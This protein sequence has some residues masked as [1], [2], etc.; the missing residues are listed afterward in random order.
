[1][2]LPDVLPI[3]SYSG[4]ASTSTVY[5]F[6][7]KVL[8]ASHVKLYIDGVLSTD[9][10]TVT[11]VGDQA[12]VDVTTSVA[13]T[14]GQQVTLRREVPLSQETDLVEGGRLREESLES[15][16]DYGVMQAQQLNEELGR[17][18]QVAPGGTGS[19]LPSSTNSTIGQDSNGDLVSRT[20]QEEL[21]HLG[22][23][24]AA[25][26]A[27]ASAAA[28]AISETNAGASETTAVASAAAAE[29]SNVNASAA[30]LDLASRSFPVV[31]IGKKLFASNITSDV[32]LNFPGGGVITLK[33]S[34][35]PYT[36]DN[37]INAENV[38]V[39]NI[40]PDI[41]NIINGDVTDADTGTDY[42]LSTG[43]TNVDN[44]TPI[45]DWSAELATDGGAT[46]ASLIDLTYYGSEQTTFTVP[47][48]LE[49]KANAT[50]E[51]PAD[52]P[53][54]SDVD[55]LA[56]GYI[57][58]VNGKI[59]LQYLPNV[60][61]IDYLQDRQDWTLL[62]ST[63]QS[64]ANGNT[65]TPAIT[66]ANPDT[67]IISF[68][69]GVKSTTGEF[70]SVIPA[71][72]DGDQSP[73]G[74]ASGETGLVLA[75]NEVI[76]FADGL[77]ATSGPKI[78]VQTAGRGSARLD[79]LLEGSGDNYFEDYLKPVV[80]AAGSLA[81][82]QNKTVDLPAVIFRQGESGTSPASRSAYATQLEDYRD[83][84][85]STATANLSRERDLIMVSY[86]TSSFGGTGTISAEAQWDLHQSTDWFRIASPV[87]PIYAAGLYSLTDN[88]HLTSAGY[89]WLGVYEGRTLT[90]IYADKQ[91]RLQPISAVANG[92][93]VEITMQV[94]VE[95]LEIDTTGV[96]LV[97]DYGLAIEDD[98]G[99]LTLSNITILGG[100]KILCDV[101]RAIT[102]NGTVRMGLD[103]DWAG[104][105]VG[106]GK[107][108]NFRDSSSDTVTI[109]SVSRNLHNWCLHSD[110]A[111]PADTGNP[112]GVESLWITKVDSTQA[113][114]DYFST[115]DLTEQGVTP[116]FTGEDDSMVMIGGT[117]PAAS[118]SL[119][120]GITPNGDTDT[121]WAVVYLD[122]SAHN[123]TSNSVAIMNGKDGTYNDDGITLV[124]NRQAVDGA[125]KITG[126]YSDGTSTNLF[127]DQDFTGW[128]LVGY[129]VDATNNKRKTFC[130][131]LAADTVEHATQL[132][133]I[134][135]FTPS[136]ERVEIGR[137][138]YTHSG[139]GVLSG[140]R[141]AMCGY[142]PTYYEA[143]DIASA[144]SY[145]ETRLGITL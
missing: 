50:L 94:P 96:P 11:G 36:E 21:D 89:A 42:G 30:V 14:S 22:V 77:S 108:T 32:V 65:N 104:S 127:I 71:V 145:A 48:P 47:L 119:S 27:A 133:T 86:Q 113:Y 140:L 93:L 12:G 34:A 15:A 6:P 66:T 144:I 91:E 58:I 53:F 7:F 75:A 38:D 28:A 80:E 8:A 126:Y 88:V 124:M 55:L 37:A 92:S 98:S 106:G 100:N 62:L 112:L 123:S 142:S 107:A 64:L 131:P 24:A 9:A 60:S 81:S 4:N 73:E 102:T 69:G 82:S 143:S 16:L 87:Y 101:D 135:G 95:P 5:P 115:N 99:S 23:G 130:S 121:F 13:Y 83:Q 139:S 39:A 109:D 19:I 67:D 31:R 97:S 120:T 46:I 79:M 116:L 111:I 76:E 125:H 84:I 129:T 141:M 29:A 54:F 61:A 49:I 68:S 74:F 136:T 57:K 114:N 44:F 117:T 63:G 134:S 103:N 56:R 78:L 70:S 72:E 33:A 59:P 10:I 1:M 20:A 138:S 132:T 105:T 85:Q 18:V 45:T 43:A 40:L 51:P 3:A 2:S 90:S 128:A 110:V 35:R 25:T 26:A 52:L 118:T 41:I 17:T 122:P 137:G